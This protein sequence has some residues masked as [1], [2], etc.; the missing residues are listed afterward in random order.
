MLVPGAGRLQFHSHRDSGRMPS[1]HC[2][3]N[4]LLL[5]I[6]YF[7]TGSSTSLLNKSLNNPQMSNDNREWWSKPPELGNLGG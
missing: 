1:S 6:T 3:P 5:N 4:R 7:L 2:R